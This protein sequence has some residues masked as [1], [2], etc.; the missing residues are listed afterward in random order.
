M[1]G[2]PVR[3][4]LGP[5][6]S[7]PA[8]MD[9]SIAALRRALLRAKLNVYDERAVALLSC[10]KT[11]H[12]VFGV[13]EWRDRLLS[14]AREFDRSA[15]QL[16]LAG[17]A[18]VF[19]LLDPYQAQCR[20]TL[21]ESNSHSAVLI[22][23]STMSAIFSGLSRAMLLAV[24][25]TASIVAFD[26]HAQPASATRGMMPYQL[27]SPD[28]RVEFCTHMRNAAT[29][30]E[31]QAIAQRMHRTIATRAK[32][33]G[34]TL[35]PGMPDG[36]PM[37]GSGDSGR[38]MMHGMDCG[39]AGASYPS[40]RSAAPSGDVP[41]G[42][43]RGIPFV[44]GGVGEDEAAALRGVTS[45]YSMRATF[46]S[47]SGEYLSGVAVQVLKPDGSL[48]FNATSEGPYLFAQIPPGH[49]SLVA[50]SDGVK[51][52]RSIVVPT[53]GGVSLTLTWQA[54]PAK[55]N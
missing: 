48:V 54:A 23:E 19:R 49:Y 39:P 31:R 21:P 6:L 1:E 52:V 8:Y 26:A 11:V 20:Q 46:A 30:A 2:V 18:R 10:C 36:Y 35:P 27:L 32:E 28:E 15:E 51:R 34:V 33:Q 12:D 29:P 55:T 44:T 5:A 53:R 25:C 37:M 22:R 13:W 16:C 42:H 38:G 24:A 4:L 43:Y 7:R 47:S 14:I 45:S 50:T 3:Y 41:V 17:S 9:V 40:G